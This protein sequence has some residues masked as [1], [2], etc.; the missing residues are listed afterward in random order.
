MGTLVPMAIRRDG[1]TQR[2]SAPSTTLILKT[3]ST[4]KHHGN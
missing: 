4:E 1:F 2:L 3:Q